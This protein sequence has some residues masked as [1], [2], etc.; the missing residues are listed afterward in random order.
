LGRHVPPGHGLVY[1]TG[2]ALARIIGERRVVLAALVGSAGWAP[3]GLTL[4]ARLDVGG[5]LGVELPGENGVWTP[6]AGSRIMRTP[7]TPW[8]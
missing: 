6:P 1:W 8:S 7:G 4:V 3:A 2:L 5:A